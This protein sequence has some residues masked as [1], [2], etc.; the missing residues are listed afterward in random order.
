MTVAGS[1]PRTCYVLATL[2]LILTPRSS[3]KP[4]NTGGDFPFIW[5]LTPLLPKLAAC[6]SPVKEITLRQADEYRG[7][8]IH[9]NNIR[10]VMNL[11]RRIGRESTGRGQVLTIR[12]RLEQAARDKNPQHTSAA[13]A[14]RAGEQCHPS[15]RGGT[16]SAL[17]PQTSSLPQRTSATVRNKSG[18]SS[19]TMRFVRPLWQRKTRMTAA[20]VLYSISPVGRGNPAAL[21]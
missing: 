21:S 11:R 2:P 15:E 1:H 18:L 8:V 4:P 7:M 19:V 16:P 10:M 9:T 5:S 13:P 17:R 12:E 6:M 20:R 14:N 3:A